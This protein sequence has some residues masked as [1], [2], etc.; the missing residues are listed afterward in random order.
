MK[1]APKPLTH[2]QGEL[3]F[4]GFVGEVAYTIQG[5]PTVPSTR[6]SLNGSAD[7]MLAAFKA[8][9][10]TLKIEGGKGL[11]ITVTAHSTGAENA[12]FEIDR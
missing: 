8:G 2:G 4:A 11:R 12:F 6:G 5:N 7:T 3:K 9:Q 1:R 10:A